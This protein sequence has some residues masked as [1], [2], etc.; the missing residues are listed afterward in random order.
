[1]QLFPMVMFVPYGQVQLFS[2]GGVPYG[3]TFPMVRRFLWSFSAMT[4][5][6]GEGAV[7]DGFRKWRLAEPLVGGG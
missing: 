7:R 4:L 5:T 1:M 2:M 3:Q 6:G